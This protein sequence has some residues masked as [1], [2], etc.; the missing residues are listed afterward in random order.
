MGGEMKMMSQENNGSVVTQQPTCETSLA[1]IK[2]YGFYY[3]HLLEHPL[4][5]GED[6]R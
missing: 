3:G 4:K 2:S 6:L 1:C 5:M